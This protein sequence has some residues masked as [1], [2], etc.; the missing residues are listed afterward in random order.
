MNTEQRL[1]FEN[2]RDS[3][4]FHRSKGGGNRGEGVSMWSKVGGVRVSKVTSQLGF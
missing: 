3:D 1:F 2:P 4:E